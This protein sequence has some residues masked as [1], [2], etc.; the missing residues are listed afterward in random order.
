MLSQETY[1]L[2]EL[3]R[4]KA[5]EIKNIKMSNEHDLSLKLSQIMIMDETKNKLNSKLKTI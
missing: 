3:L 2:S 1:R 4:I 5:E